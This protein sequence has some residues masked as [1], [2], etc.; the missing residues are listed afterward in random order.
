MITVI[1]I[2]HNE[3]TE[4][5]YVTPFI[6]L[7]GTLQDRN[8]FD[9]VHIEELPSEDGIYECTV[10]FS[11]NESY[12]A[13]LYLWFIENWYCRNRGLVVAVDDTESNDDALSKYNKR[14]REL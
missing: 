4:V 2:K 14:S 9:L 5:D 7:H 3:K 8:G 6:Y 10:R 1:P 11:D 12:E 13:K